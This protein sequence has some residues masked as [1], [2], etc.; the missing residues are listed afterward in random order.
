MKKGNGRRALVTAF[1]AASMVGVGTATPALA[2]ELHATLS[3]SNVTSGGDPDGW[4]RVKIHV[5]DN[6][7]RLCTDVEVRSVGR[8][9]SAQIH[10]GGPDDEGPVVATLDRPTKGDSEDCD[11]I[12]DELADQIQSNPGEFY[13]LVRTDDYPQGAIRG[14]LVPL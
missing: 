9:R 2:R 8:V 13:V 10:R 5:G 7:D 14:Q 6:S 12:G 4:G 11:N 3:G 1:V